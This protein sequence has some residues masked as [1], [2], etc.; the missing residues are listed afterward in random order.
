MSKDVLRRLVA[1]G[2][3]GLP[4]VDPITVV[5]RR[6][7]VVEA[8]HRVH[9]VAV[10][11][12]AVVEQAGDRRARRLPPLVG[13]AVPGAAARARSRRPD[14]RG[15]RD[16]LRVAP[17][18]ARAARRRA[19]PAREGA[20]AE[21]DELECGP[22]P[23]AARSTTARASTRGCSRSA[24]T[25]GWAS[26]G[27]R[28]ATHPVQHGCLHEVAAAADVDPD[29][30]PTAVDGCGVLTFALPL[31]RM[32]LMFAP[33]RAGRRR[34]PRGR[35]DARPPGADPRPDGG[36]QPADARAGRLDGEGRRRGPPL[37]VRGPAGSGSR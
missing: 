37:R 10:R 16:R 33:A 23:T 1:R 36:G 8:T 34:R 28:L 30:I 35:G 20:R 24:G 14:D 15:D 6:G 32:A 11:D 17:R 31:E 12:G 9:A 4:A 7:Q 22:E 19:Q 3:V 26:G 21:E 13:E 2:R 27:Y 18:L 5:V 29:E 25:K